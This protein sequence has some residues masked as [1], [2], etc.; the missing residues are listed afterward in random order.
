MGGLLSAEIVLLP[1]R[2]PTPTSP[3]RHRI[4]GTISFD[5]PFLGMHPGIIEAGLGSIFKPAAKAPPATPPRTSQSY[6]SSLVNG[7]SNLQAQNYNPRFSN[8]VQL[9]ARKGWDNALHFVNKHSKNLRQATT[10]LITSHVE[11]GSCLADYEGLKKRYCKIRMLEEEDASQRRTVI[12]EGQFTPAR[13]RFTN[14]YT[15]ST[16]RPKKPKPPCHSRSSN[17]TTATSETPSATDRERSASD[18]TGDSQQPPSFTTHEANSQISISSA[19]SLSSLPDLDTAEDTSTD[20]DSASPTT[21]T[22]TTPYIDTLPAALAKPPIPPGPGPIKQL[23]LDDLDAFWYAYT[24]HRADVKAYGHALKAYH[25][26]LHAYRKAENERHRRELKSSIEAVVFDSKAQ[27]N[28]DDPSGQIKTKNPA[29]PITTT[30]DITPNSLAAQ[31]LHARSL[32]DRR[33]R[34]FEALRAQLKKQFDEEKVRRKAESEAA[35]AQKKAGKQARRDDRKADKELVKSVIKE[36]K[37]EHKEAKRAGSSGR[38]CGPRNDIVPAGFN[39]EAG[40]SRSQSS[41]TTTATSPRPSIS[42]PTSYPP[43]KPARPSLSPGFNSTTSSFSSPSSSTL[44]ATAD[45]PTRQPSHQPSSRPPKKDRK[46]CI[47][48]PADASNSRDPT[49][50][51]VYMKDVDEVGAHCGLFFPLGAQ[52]QEGRVRRSRLGEDD[53]DDGGEEVV[54]EGS[55][56]WGERYARLVSDV[57]ERVEGWVLEAETVRVV[58]MESGGGAGGVAS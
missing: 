3:L 55:G 24:T 21:T 45:N 22:T 7:F 4:I 34:E 54:E 56:R 9:P 53:V 5:T 50:Q 13:V 17:G 6:L 32:K 31:K 41:S 14:Y 43:E 29:N 47:L 42:A 2:N 49:W 10:Q 44:P 52:G 30:N 18:M 51:R 16:G 46:F 58:L 25:R 48:P 8:D 57:A 38:V 39:P 1:S 36:R 15:A 28:S 35:R 23:F 26:S 27:A 19:S 11:F 33:K 40:S 20:P 37:A 12:P